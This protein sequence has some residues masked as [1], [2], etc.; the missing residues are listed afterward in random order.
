MIDT[1]NID[2]INRIIE[3][4]I[5]TRHQTKRTEAIDNLVRP[6][7]HVIIDSHTFKE[8]DPLPLHLTKILYLNVIYCNN[9][10]YG[11]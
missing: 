9:E 2:N 8:P 6:N 4:N 3:N 1:K 11:H 10:K 7:Q 5:S